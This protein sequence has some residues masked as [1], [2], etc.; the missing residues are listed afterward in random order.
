MSGHQDMDATLLELFRAELEINTEIIAVTCKATGAE[1][2]AHVS[3]ARRAVHSIQGAARGMDLV[4][5]V[6]LC[7]A[8]ELTLQGWEQLLPSALLESQRL[9]AAACA[10]LE[11]LRRADVA[12]QR[13]VADTSGQLVSLCKALQALRLPDADLTPDTGEYV[14]PSARSTAPRARSVP[15][16]AR[17]IPPAPAI[18]ASLL[19][20]FALE[21]EQCISILSDG[22]VALQTEPASSERWAGLARAAHSLKDAAH[23]VGLGP[24]SRLSHE[25]EASFLAAQAEWYAVG[26]REIA[27]LLRAVDL[28]NDLAKALL[29]GTPARLADLEEIALLMA[30]ELSSLLPL[31]PHAQGCEP[32]QPSALPGRGLPVTADH[33]PDCFST[34]ARESR[35]QVQRAASFTPAF[36]LLSAQQATLCDTL[37]SLER[38]LDQPPAG[39]ARELLSAAQEQAQACARVL[40]EHHTQLEQHARHAQELAERLYRQALRRIRYVAR[41]RQRRRSRQ[42]LRKQ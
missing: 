3:N 6:Q 18:E 9:L 19:A 20:L 26:S 32:G 22:L 17:S 25:V 21:S 13:W 27:I 30:D 37:A 38:S 10:Y 2:D 35:D 5:V 41:S 16:S 29:R 14:R 11:Q 34:L 12:P 1:D 4:E 36:E 8:L 23:K 28:A 42:G 7:E 24:L 15:P 39:R 40:S 33:S 31:V